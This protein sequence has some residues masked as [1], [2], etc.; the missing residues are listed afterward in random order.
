MDNV[1]QFFFLLQN[2]FNTSNFSNISLTTEEN[3]IDEYSSYRS[4]SVKFNEND[5]EKGSTN[6]MQPIWRP[7]TESDTE[8]TQYRSVELTPTTVRSSTMSAI[9]SSILPSEFEKPQRF[10]STSEQLT[11]DIQL[12]KPTPVSARFRTNEPFDSHSTQFYTATT[13][14]PYHNQKNVTSDS[15]SHME[16]Q[17]ATE[18]SQRIVN[19]SSTKNFF[20][21]DQQQQLQSQFE[22]SL[23][24]FP[25]IASP[26]PSISRQ[27]L[28]PPPTPTKFI[29]GEFRESDYDSEI[30]S[31]KIRPVWTPNSNE[32]EHL[33]Y[34]HVSPPTQNRSSS[35]PK[36]HFERIL[37]PMEFDVN[38]VEMP[39]QIK[40]IPFSPTNLRQQQTNFRAQ[41]LDR[42][43]SQKKASSQF[44][45]ASK[46]DINVMHSTPKYSRMRSPAQ[47]YHDECRS[48][49]YGKS[50]NSIGF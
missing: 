37:T 36:H 22:K 33:N 3:K 13:G 15:C 21:Y 24:P 39:S 50:M 38:C 41:T 32:L 9:P 25:F 34:R 10:T 29:P 7:R 42:S 19:V 16:I 44:L 48:S 23:E 12:F 5:I 30:E 8:T 46:D 35:V 26:C 4:S 17:E 43:R 27:K 31:I 11:R 6:K 1:K 14:P 18:S 47:S 28:R 45:A 49:Q 2:Q 20:T 40:C